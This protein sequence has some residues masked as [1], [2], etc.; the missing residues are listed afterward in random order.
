MMFFNIKS[1]QSLEE[2]SVGGNLFKFFISS[3]NNCSI[4]LL[5]VAIS[6]ELLNLQ[7]LGNLF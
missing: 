4:I 6:V 5:K 7:L 1:M 3:F 2:Q